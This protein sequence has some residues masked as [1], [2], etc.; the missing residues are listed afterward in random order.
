[1]LR[2]RATKT[3]LPGKERVFF[4]IQL[5]SYIMSFAGVWASIMDASWWIGLLFAAIT[6]CLAVFCGKKLQDIEKIRAK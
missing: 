1:M 3:V 2:M 4:V 6:I 5:A